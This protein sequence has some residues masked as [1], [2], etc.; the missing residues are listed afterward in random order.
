MGAAGESFIQSVKRTLKVTVHD[1]LLTEESLYTF[2]CGIESL[3]SSRPLTHISDDQNDHSA[4]MPN[5]TL[6]CEE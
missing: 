1:R 3:L 5:Q 4:L 6:L 2:L